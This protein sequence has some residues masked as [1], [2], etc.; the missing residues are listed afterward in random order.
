METTYIKL[1]FIYMTEAHVSWGRIFIAVYF[2][3][4]PTSKRR[5]VKIDSTERALEELRNG[6]LLVG[7]S[8]ENDGMG[9]ACGTNDTISVGKIERNT[10]GNIWI[11]LHQILK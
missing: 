5:R 6:Y 4:L 7:R 1:E 2:M 8:T 11:I 3:T 9:V 10:Q